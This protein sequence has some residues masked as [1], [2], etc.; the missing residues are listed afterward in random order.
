MQTSTPKRLRIP[1]GACCFCRRSSLLGHSALTRVSPLF[2]PSIHIL[3]QSEVLR[4]WRAR[5]R[6][7]LQLSGAFPLRV[8]ASDRRLSLT[9][10]APFLG[11]VLNLDARER[12]IAV[13]IARYCLAVRSGPVLTPRP[14]P[15]LSSHHLGESSS[16][17]KRHDGI[18]MCPADSIPPSPPC[19][20]GQDLGA[21]RELRPFYLSACHLSQHSHA[22]PTTTTAQTGM[23]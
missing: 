20:A 10:E 18:D 15:P 3:P 7:C 1:I 16:E 9:P 12:T 23:M 6:S 17:P 19:L 4:L 13:P 2:Q 8:C 14:M 5:S 11:C 21:R 22:M